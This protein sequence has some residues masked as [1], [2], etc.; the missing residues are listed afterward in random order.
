MVKAAVLYNFGE[1]LKVES[2]KLRDPQPDEVVVKLAASGVCHSD[3]S[4]QQAKLPF[5]PPV[6]LGHEGAGVIEE[7][8]KDVKHLKAGDHVVLSWVENCGR[9]HYCI[10]G[11]AHLCDAMMASMM[12]GSEHVF[13]KDGTMIARMAGVASFAE[14]TVVRASAAIKIPDDVPLDRACLV[15][16][17]VMTGVGAVVN[18]AK[19]Q[20][21]DTVA[22][23]GCGGV[24]LNVVQGAVLAGAGRVIA[25]DLAPA[26]LELAKTF[27]A[28]DLVNGKDGNAP[29]QI[30][31]LTGGL[32]VDYAFEVIGVPAV[33][34]QAYLSLKR[35]G[36]CIVVGVPPIGAMV[37]I[38]GQMISLEEKSIIGSLY[39]SAN[40][41]RDMPRLIELYQR[42]RLK[43]DELV[44]KRIKLEDV[45]AAF[46][47]MEKGAVARSVIV[48]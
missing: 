36:K 41:K 26:K 1:A 22:V 11:H 43:L 17:G 32:G 19:V 14:R 4:V 31:E 42:K 44:S 16:C 3:L 20:P 12:A 30:R 5:P 35:G 7:V 2:L 9:C 38:P 34:Q 47:D 39:G 25:V 6:V 18:T 21:G 23:Y 13:E 48:F 28:T 8:G 10:A 15:G 27:G 37:E 46:A 29:D 33:I 45:N 24:G 40:M